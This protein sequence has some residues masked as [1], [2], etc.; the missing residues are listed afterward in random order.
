VLYELRINRALHTTWRNPR[1]P[2]TEPI[3]TKWIAV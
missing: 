2:D 1:Q 3:H